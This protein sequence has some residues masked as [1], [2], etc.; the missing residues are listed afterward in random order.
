MFD[1]NVDPAVNLGAIGGVIGHEV[2]HGFDDEGRKIEVS[3]ALRDWWTKGDAASFQA[4]SQKLVEQ[5][6]QLEPFPGVNEARQPFGIYRSSND[7]SQT[8]P[9]GGSTIGAPGHA[10]CRTLARL[11]SRRYQVQAYCKTGPIWAY[12]GF[13]I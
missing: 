1:P 10:H 6:S 8:F 9:A 5:Y 2:R 7:S 13:G 4:H 11:P 12:A 3:S